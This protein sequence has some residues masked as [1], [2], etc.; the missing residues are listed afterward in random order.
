MAGA[1]TLIAMGADRAA[2]IAVPLLLMEQFAQLSL[3]PMR[4]RSALAA[5]ASSVFDE[6][7]TA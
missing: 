7:R 4:V 6:V 5:L 2:A 3:D 1:S